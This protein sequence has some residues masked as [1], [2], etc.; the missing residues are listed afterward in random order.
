[1]STP[2]R[3][4]VIPGVFDT[5]HAGGLLLRPVKNMGDRKVRIRKSAARMD[6]IRRR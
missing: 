6:E 4:H 5:L 2:D 3:V 1:M